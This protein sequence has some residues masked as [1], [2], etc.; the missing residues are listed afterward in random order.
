[1]QI[2]KICKNKN[3]IINIMFVTIILLV[4][5]SI[6]LVVE[7]NEIISNSE[8]LN[9]EITV[10]ESKVLENSNKFKEEILILEKENI[11]LNEQ[12]AELK[13]ESSQEKDNNDSTD[14]I[15]NTISNTTSNTVSN[16]VVTTT[17]SS[18]VSAYERDM[19]A[20]MVWAESR[21]EDKKGQVLV[22]N[23]IMN[24]V[25]DPSFPNTIEGVIFQKN[26]FSPI[27]DGSF[28]SAKPTKEHYDSVDLALSG[29]DYSQGALFFNGA[30][31]NSYASKNKTFL[32]RHQNHDFYK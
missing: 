21:G 23:V 24:R 13:T 10:L 16:M 15:S 27:N 25:K 32:F 26:A 2:T 3:Y 9:D 17:S 11:E 18:S 4:L 8:K 5:I 29:T 12:I 14:I 28:N 22:A 19:L 30:G 20:K 7:K 1:M 31:L 6:S